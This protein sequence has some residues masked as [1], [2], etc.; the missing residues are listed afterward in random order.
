[1]TH[2]FGA[3]F[4]AAFRLGFSHFS[5]RTFLFQ[6]VPIIAFALTAILHAQ[7]EPPP[8][9]DAPLPKFPKR[10]I[11]NSLEEWRD[12]D[13]QLLESARKFNDLSSRKKKLDE[14]LGDARENSDPQDFTPGRIIK[15]RTSADLMSDLEGLL[16]DLR[17]QREKIGRIA[18]SV[19]ASRDELG[20]LLESRRVEI[21]SNPVA[22]RTAEQSTELNRIHAWQRSLAVGMEDGPQEFYLELLGHELAPELLESAR[23]GRRPRGDKKSDDPTRS[24]KDR[25]E[26]GPPPDRPGPEPGMNAFDPRRDN[27]PEAMDERIHRLERSQRAQQAIIRRQRE[28]IESLRERLAMY[29]PVSESTPI[30]E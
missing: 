14:R 10:E 23:D 12:L 11:I 8:R 1:M 29:E 28:E 27:L 9:A 6:C 26:G 21:E 18:W 22:S 13:A 2:F 25:I 30:P 20:S 15:R 17:K 16:G 19:S 7:P 5:F 4:S 3:R 24:K